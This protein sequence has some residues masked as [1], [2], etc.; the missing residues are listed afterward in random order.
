[1]SPFAPHFLLDHRRRVTRALWGQ[2]VTFFSATPLIVAEDRLSIASAI[3]F[4]L[5]YGRSKQFILSRCSVEGYRDRR[6]AMTLA[7]ARRYFESQPA[8]IYTGPNLQRQTISTTET[9]FT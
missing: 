5:D 1:M 3:R 8:R 4:P 6:L 2:P 9:T 7:C